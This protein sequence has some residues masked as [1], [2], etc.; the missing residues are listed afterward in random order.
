MKNKINLFDCD[1]EFVENRLGNNTIEYVQESLKD[2]KRW[3]NSHAPF[4]VCDMNGCIGETF[5]FQKDGKLFARGKKYSQLFRDPNDLYFYL[6]KD[7]RIK[8]ITLVFNPNDLKP[9]KIDE[10]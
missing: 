3:N 5:L 6:K 4:D 1:I 8:N 7:K 9:F 2:I 10:K